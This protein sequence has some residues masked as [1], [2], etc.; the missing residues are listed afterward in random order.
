MK[1]TAVEWLAEKYDYAYWMVKR[2]EISPVL[3]EQWKKHYLEQA[4]EMEKQQIIGCFI[5]VS[6]ALLGD[7][8]DDKQECKLK[9]AAERYYHETFKSE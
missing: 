6:H 4:K 7:N 2:N 3:A 9:E 1:Q 5:E 8:M